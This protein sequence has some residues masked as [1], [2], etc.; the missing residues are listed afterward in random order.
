MR[1]ALVN[2]NKVVNIIDTD[3]IPVGMYD[4]NLAVES[5]TA[6]I[7]DSYV[8]GLFVPDVIEAPEIPEEVPSIVPLYKTKG[9]SRSEYIK[10]FTLKEQALYFRF[11][12]NMYGN[13]S[14]MPTGTVTLRDVATDIGS[15][16]T[17][18]EIM[19]IGKGLFKFSS[20]DNGFDVVSPTVIAG[21]KSM[22]LLGMLD[23]PA[24]VTTILKGKLL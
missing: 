16:L 19:I 15:P 6:R 21:V 1:V 7:G 10:L 11:M 23:S 24:R 12:D 8:N 5:A 22:G 3:R 4:H 18:M 9:L 14:F 2:L 17:Y 20:P 13:L